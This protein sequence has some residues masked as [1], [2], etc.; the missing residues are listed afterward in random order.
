MEERHFGPVTFI[1]GENQGKY[2]FCHS[3]YIEGAGVLIDPASNRERLVE[4]RENS[5]VEEVW[6][7]HWHEDHI[8]HLDL[9]D[10]LPLC[11]ME[12]D[13]PPL[14]DLDLFLDSYGEISGKEREQYRGMLME[15]FHFRPRKPTSFLKSGEIIHFDTVTVEVISAPGHTP[16][17]LAL[18]F[19]EPGIL[20][21]ADYD[22][23][24]FGPWYGDVNSSIDDTIKSV[25]H[26]R[27][28]PANVW[29]TCHE[30][31]VFEEEP[32]SLWDQYL[33]VIAERERKLLNQLQEPQTFADIV[34]AWIIYGKPREPKELFEFGERLLMKKHLEKLMNEGVV[35]MEGERYYKT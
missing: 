7:S 29:L 2:P 33:N 15:L 26:L 13:A 8:M 12:P 3:I 22:L 23:T 17:H 27:N 19:E 18:F 16:G 24:E 11:I 25:K 28:I 30:T 4:L 32:G 10:D 5:G 20:F 35:A 21:M 34:G 9:F 6:L 14:S 1:P 31:G